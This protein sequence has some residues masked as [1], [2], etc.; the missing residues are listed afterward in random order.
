MATTHGFKDGPL[1]GEV[2]PQWLAGLTIYV[3]L[4][5][6]QVSDADQIMKLNLMNDNVLIFLIMF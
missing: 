4:C 1:T 3:S 5:L 6:A 2:E